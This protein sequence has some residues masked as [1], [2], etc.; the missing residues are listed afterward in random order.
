MRKVEHLAKLITSPLRAQ[1]FSRNLVVLGVAI[2]GTYL[3]VLSHAS[4][5]PFS[6]ITD[7]TATPAGASNNALQIIGAGDATGAITATSAFD[8]ITVRARGLTCTSAPTLQLKLD[9]AAVLPATSLSV[10]VRRCRW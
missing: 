2:L 10:T 7:P 4:P 8:T 3:L 9:G 1:R 5:A 6:L